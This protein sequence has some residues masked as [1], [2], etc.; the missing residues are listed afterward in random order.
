MI[1]KALLKHRIKRLTKTYV[2]LSFD[3]FKSALDDESSLDVLVEM[4]G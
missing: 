2:T 1:S 3:D 4:I